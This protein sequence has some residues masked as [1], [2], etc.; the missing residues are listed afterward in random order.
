[1][2]F[3]IAPSILSADF[4]KLGDEI[5]KIEKFHNSWIHLDIMDGNFVPQ[6]TF[7][8]PLVKCLRKK[9]SL[10]FDV[11]LMVDSPEKQVPQFI[12]AGANYIT[13]HIESSI[14]PIELINKLK[15]SKVKAGISLRPSTPIS[16]IENLLPYI[17]LLL[18]MSVEPGFSGQKFI[19]PSLERIKTVKALKENNHFNFL[20]SVDG[21][22]N[23]ETAEN[24]LLAGADVLV[25]G[26]Y[27]FGT[28]FQEV[29][30]FI[31]NLRK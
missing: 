7:G 14:S 17:D 8:S 13:F 10:V 15:D 1:M 21:G 31:S 12:E 29:E 22:I 28:P 18:I 5:K 11:H 6:I 27:F 26:S 2:N 19:Y 4:S 3:L 30:N 24:V 16:S 20:I 25:M 23:K 9:S